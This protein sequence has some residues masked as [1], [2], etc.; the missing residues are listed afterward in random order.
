MLVTC[1]PAP[2]QVIRERSTPFSN[3]HNLARRKSRPEA[4][5]EVSSAQRS[6]PSASASEEIARCHERVRTS[7]KESQ[8]SK[9]EDAS[10]SAWTGPSSS[11]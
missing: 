5:F 8:A 3:N 2:S 9:K 6:I 10:V 1:S 11:M 7:R 4:T